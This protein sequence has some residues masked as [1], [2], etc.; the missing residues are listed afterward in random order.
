MGGAAEEN[1]NTFSCFYTNM[2][3]NDIGKYFWIGVAGGFRKQTMH[4]YIPAEA[5]SHVQTLNWRFN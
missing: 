1:S 4:A 3:L 5:S 2:A